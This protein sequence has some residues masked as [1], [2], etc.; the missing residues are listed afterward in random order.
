MRQ[1]TP[2]LP[3]LGGEAVPAPQ[4]AGPDDGTAGP[5]GHTVPES[6]VLRPFPDVGLVSSLHVP[7]FLPGLAGERCQPSA[8]RIRTE[9][10]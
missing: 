9:S 1:T 10:P 7:S 6:V 8:V 4:T 3:G 5:R 2:G